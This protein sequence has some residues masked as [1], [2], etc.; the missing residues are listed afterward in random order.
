M[1]RSSGDEMKFIK[2]I[3]KQKKS[4]FI[5]FMKDG[6]GAF[7]IL[8]DGQTREHCSK[9]RNFDNTSKNVKIHS[10]SR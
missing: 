9:I 8:L 5:V 2:K 3:G 4:F 1:Y 7:F 10:N 6:R